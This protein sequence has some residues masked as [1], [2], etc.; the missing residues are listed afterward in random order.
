VF[1]FYVP[2]NSKEAQKLYERLAKLCFSHLPAKHA[3]KL[4]HSDLMSAKDLK[5]L[6]SS[7]DLIQ[8]LPKALRDFALEIENNPN[9]FLVVQRAK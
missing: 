5:G 8:A 7:V 9:F 3:L 2:D 1:S 4:I 6:S